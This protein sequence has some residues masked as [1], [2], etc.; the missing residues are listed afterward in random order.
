MSILGS[1]YGWSKYLVKK[2]RVL[3]ATS[4]AKRPCSLRPGGVQTR[5]ATPS[6]VLD[7]TTSNSPTQKATR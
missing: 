7:S 4:R 6:A 3:Q 1:G 2:E 5:T